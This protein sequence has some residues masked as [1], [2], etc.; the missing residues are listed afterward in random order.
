MSQIT[1]PKELAC[2][3]IDVTG[4]SF[5]RGSFF[6]SIPWG[7]LMFTADE[8]FQNMIVSVVDM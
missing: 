1:V 4:V 8:R 6:T 3:Y 2:S 5:Y 7:T